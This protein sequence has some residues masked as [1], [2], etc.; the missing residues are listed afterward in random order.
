MFGVAMMWRQILPHPNGPLCTF[1]PRTQK[2]PPS[3]HSDRSASGVEESTTWD[4][5]P[6]QD[7]TCHLGRFLGSLPFARNDMSVGGS[8]FLHRLYLPRPGTAHRPFPTYYTERI[9][10]NNVCRPNNCQLSTVNSIIV[11]C[12]LSIVNCQFEPSSTSTNPPTVISSGVTAQSTA[13]TVTPAA[14]A[15]RRVAAKAGSVWSLGWRETTGF[16]WMT[17]ST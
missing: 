1:R 5:E 8:G 7:K 15:C 9:K 12:Q 2:T 17:N 13:R 3:C 16:I 11:N 10:M 6:P 14:A 4:N